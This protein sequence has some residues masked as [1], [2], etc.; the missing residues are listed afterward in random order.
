MRK[1]NTK[2]NITEINILLLDDDLDMLDSLKNIIERTGYK[3]FITNNDEEAIN[4]IN[5]ANPRIDILIVDYLMIG[6]TGID[7]VNKVR[8]FN[9]D[10][11]IILLTGFVNN[12]PWNCAIKQFD[13]DSY[14]EKDVNFKDLLLKIEIAVKSIIKYKPFLSNDGLK[15]E[16]RLKYLR[17]N[18]NKTQDEVAEYLN[19]GRSTIGAYEAGT[20]KPGFDNIRKLAELFEVSY[21]Y[22]LG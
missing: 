10:L 20:I 17:I 3:C 13:I 2:N 6:V 22:L 7:V 5:S 19:V 15:F 11:Y 4:R 9:R 1:E 16:E 21:D 18:K 12:M 8:R 14:A